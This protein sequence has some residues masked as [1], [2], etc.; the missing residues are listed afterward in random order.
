M[1]S[2]KHYTGN[3]ALGFFPA[4][5][6]NNHMQ[7]ALLSGALKSRN[8]FNVINFIMSEYFSYIRI[9]SPF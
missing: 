8:Y 5:I 3:K 4:Y 6:L 1:L 7:I 2:V 9:E